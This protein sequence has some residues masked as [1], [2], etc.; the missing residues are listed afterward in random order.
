MSIFEKASREKLRFQHKGICTVDD[1]WELPL[2]SL[3]A[4][5]KDLNAKVKAQ[6]EESLLDVKSA[7][8]E[9]V[10]LQ[11]EIVKHIVTVRLQE[12]QERRDAV[13]KSEQ[14]KKLLGILAKKQD[15]ELENLSIEELT[16]QINEM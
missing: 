6:K 11:V 5:Y 1:L 8:D 9:T 15:S 7:A 14:K 3:D 4:I 13:A 2:R 16:K 10:A 12:A